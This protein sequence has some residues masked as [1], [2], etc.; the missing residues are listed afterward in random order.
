MP[1]P[2]L[3]LPEIITTRLAEFSRRQKL[4]LFWRGVAEA[5][6]V[7]SGGV[8]L[9]AVLL[10]LWRAPLWPRAFL[11]AA[12]YLAA[13]LWL[14]FRAVVPLLTRA[15]LREGAL[16][17]ERAAEGRFQERVSSAVELACSGDEPGVSSWMKRQTINLAAEEIQSCDTRRL[18]TF[19][20]AVKAWKRAGA[21]AGFFGLALLVPGFAPRALLALNPYASTAPLSHIKLAVTPGSCRLKSGSPLEIKVSSSSSLAEATL[22]ARWQDGFEEKVQMSRTDTNEFAIKLPP[23]TQGLRYTVR[24][25]D[26]QSGPFQV[27]LDMPPRIVRAQLDIRPPAYTGLSNRVVEGGSADLLE[28]SKVRLVVEATAE[29]VAEAQFLAEDMPPRKMAAGKGGLTLDL[30]PTRTLN[31]QVRLVGANGL[32]AEPSPKWVLR[33]LSD[34]PPSTRLTV[35]GSESGLVQRDEV[36]RVDVESID[37]VG[38]RSVELVTLNGETATDLKRLFPR[39]DAGATG[40]GRLERSAK[41]GMVYNLAD[42]NLITGDDIQLQVIATDLRG[43][44]GR[45]EPVALS[46]GSIKKALEAQLASRLKLLV[47]GL[48]AQMDHLQQTRASWQSIGRN[49]REEEPESQLPALAMVESRLAEFGGE[50]GRIGEQLVSESETN[51]VAD[52]RFLYRLGTTIS[53]WARQHRQ[54][55]NESCRELVKASGTNVYQAF[56]LTREMFSRGLK[57]LEQYKYAVFVLEAAF[58]ADVLSTRCEGAQGRYKRA[59]PVL[60]GQRPAEPQVPGSGPG[61][62][63]TFFEGIKLDGTVL[64]RKVANPRFDNY[65]PGNRRENWSV[66]YEGEMHIKES[67]DWT[68]ACTTDDGV[69]LLLDGKSLLPE[70]AWTPHAATQFKADLALQAGWHPVRIE[71]FQGSSESKLQFQAGKKGQALQEVPVDWLRPPRPSAPRFDPATNAALNLALQKA[72]KE[73]LRNSLEVPASVPPALVGFTNEIHNENLARITRESF[74][75]GAALTTNLLTFAEWKAELAQQAESQ[76]DTLTG[77]S[78]EALKLIR[79]ELERYRWRYEG[80]A[81]L[82]EIKNALDELR[83]IN[84]ELRRQPH[85]PKRERTEQE[86]A[87]IDLAKAWQRELDRAAATAAHQFFETAKQTDA[88]LA[89]RTHALNAITK[90]E[91]EFQPEVGK[92]AKTL[93]E[94]GNKDQMAGR[95]DQRLNALEERYRQLNEMQEQMNREHIAAEARRALP[96]ARTFARA[97]KQATNSTLP[98]KY[99]RMRQGVTEVQKAQRVAGDYDAARRL[100]TLAGTSPEKAKGKETADELRSWATRTENNP[101]SLAQ[102]IPPP[103]QRETAELEKSQTTP[104]ESANQLARPR[105]AMAL[106]AARLGRQNDR[107]TAV[108]YEFLGQDLGALIETPAQLNANTLS[109]L[110]D[111]ALALAGKKGEQARQ[112]EIAAA[113]TRLEKMVRDLPNTPPALAAQ[114]EGLSATAMQAAGDAASREPLGRDLGEMARS[115]PHPGEWTESTIPAEIAA[116]AAA[117][118]LEG[119]QAAPQQWDSYAEASQTLADAARQLRMDAAVAQMDALNPYASPELAGDA[120]LRSETGPSQTGPVKMDGPVGKALTQPL[121]MPGVADPGEWARLAER[122]RQAIRSSGIEHFSEEQQVAIRAYF[123][124]LSSEK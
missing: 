75:T 42:L 43:Q 83:E 62:L 87:R 56:S 7:L 78:K 124:K 107:K 72:V 35:P 25:A 15:P 39:A 84:N 38:L 110:T 51:D 46:I 95:V 14:V 55:M 103:M 3:I 13:V 102:T 21:L 70:N 104:A 82:K 27:K 40:T 36:L 20:P 71:F 59:L 85:N 24:S 80:A 11:S 18:L 108:A 90:L 65:A 111:R 31:Y 44:V 45:S 89:E 8:L 34:L 109:P 41:E 105:L 74:P 2:P 9:L 23:L 32:E 96:P 81:A 68:L 4:V 54:V 77:V 48:E 88:T 120:D 67:A 10:W 26:A 106:E 5:V 93:D 6:L 52:A 33:V 64:E 118:S 1:E 79:E 50:V 57:D 16:E 19:V 28:G 60:R 86:Q 117:D 113:N 94:A 76:A 47:S 63:A 100:E 122:L 92:L 69:R 61:L 37:D 119:I 17:L 30:E 112:E 22:V 29:P 53:A 123:E 115:A 97:Q 116:G 66:R 98:E 114:L 12:V 101:P 58:E 73:R 49:Y 99:E 91:N 121:P